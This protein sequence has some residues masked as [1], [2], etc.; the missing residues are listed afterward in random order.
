MSVN[1]AARLYANR[2]LFL[3]FVGREL[4]NRYVG[5]VSGALWA[6]LHPIAQLAIFAFVF[7]AIFRSRAGN[8]DESQYIAFY[9]CGLWPWI[10][11]REGLA[12][13]TASLQNAAHLIKKIAFPNEVLVGAA[14]TATFVVHL[15]GFTL[16]LLGAETLRPAHRF[17]RHPGRRDDLHQ[18][19][20][21]RL[22]ISLAL[23]AIQLI[24]RDVEQVL[25]PV[26]DLLFFLT[27]ILY[28]LAAVPKSLQPVVSANPLTYLLE[29]LHEALLFKPA[30]PGLWDLIAILCAALVLLAGYAI[31]KR[32]SP[33]FEDFV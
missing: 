27:P 11:F 5:S 12:R 28:P 6:V 26:L 3:S 22:G 31:F 30:L 32:L 4:R 8:L 16:A 10:A 9:A 17:H 2:A 7:A 21:G 33:H 13:G 23:S 15:G 20:P 14:V 25:G 18:P 1:N 24:I 29:R 19:V